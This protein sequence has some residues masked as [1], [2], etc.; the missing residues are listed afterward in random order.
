MA[1]MTED[2]SKLSNDCFGC[3]MV[4]DMANTTMTTCF[5]AEAKAAMKKAA[6]DVCCADT[7]STD[8]DMDGVSDA[9][10]MNA[11]IYGDMGATADEAKATQADCADIDA[12][13]KV[14]KACKA[15]MWELM[16]KCEEEK[17]AAATTAAAGGA[18][19]GGAAGGGAA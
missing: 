18:A 4:A 3:F 6:L 10:F 1:Q 15:K 13:D 12:G 17:D 11:G 16:G 7:K 19:G 5:D 14:T 9:C 2:A 8:T